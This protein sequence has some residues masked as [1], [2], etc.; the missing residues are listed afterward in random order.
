[1]RWYTA[2]ATWAAKCR[3][4]APVLALLGSW[5]R[6]DFPRERRRGA[7]ARVAWSLCL[8]AR[9]RWRQGERRD[10]NA[11]LTVK[12]NEKLSFFFPPWNSRH[13]VENCCTVL[14]VRNCRP[15]EADEG[16]EWK[17]RTNKNRSRTGQRYV[18]SFGR[19]SAIVSQLLKERLKH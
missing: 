1:M 10:R 7:C 3:A 9:I 16:K 4:S 6:G 11:L 12:R 13:L 15:V 2:L 5:R 14:F 8:A 17:R 19:E 18:R